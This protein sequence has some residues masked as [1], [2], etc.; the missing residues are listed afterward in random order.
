MQFR[1]ILEDHLF[2]EQIHGAQYGKNHEA[3]HKLVYGSNMFFFFQSVDIRKFRMEKFYQNNASRI[4]KYSF[5]MHEICVSFYGR[6]KNR[7]S[8]LGQLGIIYEVVCPVFLIVSLQQKGQV[9]R[10]SVDLVRQI[11][12]SSAKMILINVLV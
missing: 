9:I 10:D 1:K 2:S 7:I 4:M 5:K 3:E 8:V 6:K 12:S 11:R